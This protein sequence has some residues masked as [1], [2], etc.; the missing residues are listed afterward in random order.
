M[1]AELLK[2]LK[3]VLKDERRAGRILKRY[4]T[5]RIALIWTLH[6]V[7]T[8]A[9][10]RDRALTNDEAVKLLQM[11]RDNHNPQYGL[12]WSDFTCYIEQY[13]PDRKMTSPEIRRFVRRNQLTIARS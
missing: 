12:R 6:D 4:W 11:M 3:P 8:A 5:T 9:N 13:Q 2:V 7:H 1:T 10:E